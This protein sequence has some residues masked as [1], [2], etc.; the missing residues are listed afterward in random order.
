MTLQ[1]L[2]L[3]T[4]E[5]VDWENTEEHIRCS[6]IDICKKIFQETEVIHFSISESVTQD[7]NE[8]RHLF[9]WIILKSRRGV[10]Y[11][12]PFWRVYFGTTTF[13]NMVRE[14]MYKAHSEFYQSLLKENNARHRCPSTNHHLR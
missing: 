14:Y 3:D 2:A 13:R 4:I 8:W 11:P 9:R 12:P 10:F 6:S 7:I 5:P 1:Y